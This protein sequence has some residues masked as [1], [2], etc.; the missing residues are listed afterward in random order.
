MQHENSFKTGFMYYLY[1]VLCLQNSANQVIEK[2]DLICP[3]L[4]F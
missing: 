2:P 1:L 3:R 4:G